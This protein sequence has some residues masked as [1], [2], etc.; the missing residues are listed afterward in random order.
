MNIPDKKTIDSL[1]TPEK[2]RLVHSQ[3]LNQAMSENGGDILKAHKTVKTLCPQ[4]TDKLNSFDIKLRDGGGAALANGD[5]SKVPAPTPENCRALG[6]PED[7]DL[8]LYAPCFAANQKQLATLDAPAVFQ[9]LADAYAAQRGVDDVQARAIA[10]VNAP[11]LAAKAGC[12][13]AASKLQ[14]GL[15]SP[16]DGFQ[17]ANPPAPASKQNLFQA[18]PRYS[19]PFMRTANP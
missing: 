18:F 4:L 12:S 7:I 19:N 9:A 16:G 3:L 13:D 6:L 8:S 14:A 5:A 15:P 10:A 1:D 11:V 2:A 17:S